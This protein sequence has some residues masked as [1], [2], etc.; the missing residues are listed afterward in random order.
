MS[1][2]ARDKVRERA[3]TA[4]ELAVACGLAPEAWYLGVLRRCGC[5]D[6]EG[7]I[8]RLHDLEEAGHVNGGRVS[9]CVDERDAH[10]TVKADGTVESDSTVNADKF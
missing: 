3:V 10:G 8:N 1:C 7:D 9:E 4:H 6:D 5:L 2:G